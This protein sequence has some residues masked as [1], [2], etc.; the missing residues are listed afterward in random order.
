MEALYL[1]LAGNA[2][3]LILSALARNMPKPE[4]L[5]KNIWYTWIYNTVQYVLANPD[6]SGFRF[7]SNGNVP[8]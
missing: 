2:T 6:K 3:S 4:E 1:F 5:G 7:R 8:S